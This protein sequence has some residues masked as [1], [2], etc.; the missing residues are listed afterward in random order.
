MF[1]RYNCNPTGKQVGDCVIRA[2]AT[3]LGEE[4]E[5]VYAGVALQGFIMC[6][7]PSAN[8]VWSAYLKHRGFVRRLL[9]DDCP[10][11]Y[12]VVDFCADH[13]EGVY[14]LS[15]DGHVVTVINGKY[16]DTWDSGAEVPM[17]YWEKKKEED[18]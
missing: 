5:K 11:C 9:P 1:R 6:D 8:H 2:I 14:I 7:M 10:D 15:I 17:F 18:K 16:Y 3:A 4:W 13:P 12:R